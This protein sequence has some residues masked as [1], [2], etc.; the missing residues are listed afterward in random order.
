MGEDAQMIEDGNARQLLNLAREHRADILIAGGRNQYTA[1]KARLPFLD[2]NQER[3]HGYA[4]YQG[5]ITLARQLTR[6]LETRYGTPCG[7]PR[8]GAPLRLRR[9]VET[10]AVAA[11]DPIPQRLNERERAHG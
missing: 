11:A 8:P 6:A 4:G 5:M 7:G 9:G 10:A 2:V 1:L 3:E